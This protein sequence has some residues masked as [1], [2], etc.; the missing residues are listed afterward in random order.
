MPR[1]PREPAI[2]HAPPVPGVLNDLPP[3]RAE[4][5]APAEP[6][7]QQ[8]RD[9]DRA[10]HRAPAPV[11]PQGRAEAGEQEWSEQ[12]SNGGGDGSNRDE[13][14]GDVSDLGEPVREPGKRALGLNDRPPA[15]TSLQYEH[16]APDA[17]HVAVGEVLVGEKLAVRVLHSRGGTGAF[18]ELPLMVPDPGRAR[19][20]DD[21]G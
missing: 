7:G 2:H 17:I 4:T 13:P 3:G 12:E 11:G 16:A 5:G 14:E 15:G 1:R 8:G 19:G 9:G 21:S 18:H 10:K 6:P 20:W